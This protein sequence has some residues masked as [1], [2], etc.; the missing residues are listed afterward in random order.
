MALSEI[1][2]ARVRRALDAFMAKRRPPANI[3]DRL[4]LGS[5]VS[6]QSVE[7]FEVRPPWRGNPGEKH[8]SPVA[9]A[10]SGVAAR[11]GVSSVRWLGGERSV[12]G[13]R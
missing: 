1:E 3:R 6:G 12:L 4:D 9:K 5:R 11:E 8:E 13:R 10:T 2:V 7:I